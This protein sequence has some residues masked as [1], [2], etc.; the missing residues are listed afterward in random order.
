MLKIRKFK[1]NLR[2]GPEYESYEKISA[3]FM[4]TISY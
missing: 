3:I 2:D 1:S 4:L